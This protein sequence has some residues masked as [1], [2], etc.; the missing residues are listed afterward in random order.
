MP[1]YKIVIC[2]LLA[3]VS[4]YIGFLHKNIRE[5]KGTGNEKEKKQ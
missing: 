1:L 5:L 4:L 3:F 2:I